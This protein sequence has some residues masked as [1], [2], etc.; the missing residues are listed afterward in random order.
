MTQRRANGPGRGTSRADAVPRGR[1]DAAPDCA[2]DASDAGEE[3]VAEA[4][5]PLLRH[6][7]PAPAD[8]RAQIFAFAAFTVGHGDRLRSRR[9]RGK[10]CDRARFRRRE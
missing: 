7:T 3:A 4:G 10:R 9:N 5:H 6:L 2:A 1:D 8:A